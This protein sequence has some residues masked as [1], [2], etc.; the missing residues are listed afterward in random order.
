MNGIRPLKELR[1]LKL[2]GNNI[3][4]IEIMDCLIL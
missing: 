4:I 3:K 2:T 1:S